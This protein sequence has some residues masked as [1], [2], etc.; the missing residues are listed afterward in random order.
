MSQRRVSIDPAKQKAVDEISKAQ[1]K[2]SGPRLIVGDISLDG[3]RFR[4]I[5]AIAHIMMDIE[6]QAQLKTYDRDSIMNLR[7]IMSII[8][9]LTKEEKEYLDT[10]STEE[11]ERISKE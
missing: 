9:D 8:K 7:D 5:R 6:G 3:L 11:L 4:G 10:L 1:D 2:K